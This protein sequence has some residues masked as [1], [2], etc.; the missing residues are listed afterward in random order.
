M[1]RLGQPV[2]LTAPG[3]RSFLGATRRVCNGILGVGATLRLEASEFGLEA[4]ALVG[5]AT[6]RRDQESMA[7][8]SPR[9]RT[10][11]RRASG[12]IVSRV[13]DVGPAL[14][15]RSAAQ[16]GQLTDSISNSCSKPPGVRLRCSTVWNLMRLPSAATPAAL[17]VKP[18]VTPWRL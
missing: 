13:D 10:T 2:A 17:N 9:S 16:S 5:A 14:P 3:S 1:S 8:I 12:Y 4:L 15:V 11:R 18:L 6:V 7:S